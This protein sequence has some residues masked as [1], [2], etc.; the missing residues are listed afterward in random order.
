MLPWDTMKT[1]ETYTTLR[2][3]PAFGV[4]D[5][6]CRLEAGRS[7]RAIAFDRVVD[8]E[9]GE[10]FRLPQLQAANPTWYFVGLGFN[11]RQPDVTIEQLIRE[12]VRCNE[13][14]QVDQLY[15]ITLDA[16]PRAAPTTRATW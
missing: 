10:V 4:D 7:Y 12:S 8:V 2:E 14:L 9:T 15:T 3:L 11:P 13:G 6:D 1:N 5:D 16:C